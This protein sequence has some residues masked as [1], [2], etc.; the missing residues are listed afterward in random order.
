MPDRTQDP[1]LLTPGPLTTSPT[2]KQAMLRDW[3][4]RDAEFIEMTARV[5]REIENIAGVDAAQPSHVC[6]PIQGSGTFAVEAAI[7]SLVPRDG[8]VLV[9]VNGAYGERIVK[10]CDYHQRA[11]EMLETAENEPSSVADLRAELDA[12]PAISHV[13]AVHC[14]TTSGILNPLAEIARACA[15]AGRALI[16][17]AMSSFAALPLDLAR[18][19]C[20]GLIASA[21][22]CLEGV[23]GI[24]FVLVE[25]DA[26]AAAKGNANALTLDLHDQA[27]YLAQSGQWRFTPPTHV[28][29]AL[30]QALREHQA[31]GGVAGRGERY[32]RNCRVLVDGM[33][34][35]GFETYLSDNLQA[36]IIVTFHTPQH[37][38][39]EFEDFYNRLRDKGIAIYPGKLTKADSFRM[40]CIGHL[41]EADMTAAVT[42]VAQVISDMGMVLK[43]GG[44]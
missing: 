28:L 6:V 31:E 1:L 34:E 7:T 35:L 11:V 25:K 21:N 43:P 17:D 24:G 22:K 18:I 15:G 38:A 14:E 2:V 3:G 41:F 8:K 42:A 36:P 44:D 39:F 26:L 16:I 37:A 32:R 30:D 27:H 10:I 29:A 19:P 40:G 13:V 12:D 5:C 23:P 4:S 20:A 9:L 33:R